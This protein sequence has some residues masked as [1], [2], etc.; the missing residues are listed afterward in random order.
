[1]IWCHG[2]RSTTPKCHG[3][4]SATRNFLSP[5]QM[6]RTSVPE[7]K[8]SKSE[9]D[10][11][12]FGP[13]A[14][15]AAVL[16]PGVAR[17]ARPTRKLPPVTGSRAVREF[18]ESDHAFGNASRFRSGLDFGPSALRAAAAVAG[19]AR[20]VWRVR[21]LPPVMVSGAVKE[22]CRSDRRCRNAS[23]LSVTAVCCH[24]FALACLVSCTLLPI[25]SN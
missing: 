2:L 15:R 9:A 24:L 14:L 16:E 21:K 10:V 3:L 5:S 1:M 7:A 8:F 6:S 12:D 19:V 4:R 20:A 22:F 17:A 23:S 11:P 13:R 18:C 25:Q